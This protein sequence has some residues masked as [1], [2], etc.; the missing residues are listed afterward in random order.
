MEDLI[1]K[2]R[3]KFDLEVNDMADAWK[4]V[5]WLEEKGW[6]VYIIT[7]KDRKQVDAWHPRYGTLFA[8]FGEVPNFGS[9]L[10]GIL[11]V[12]LL[13]KEIEENGFKRTK[14]R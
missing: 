12:A 9:I 5:E 7:A 13:A 10:E 14:A 4:L 6:V 2:V 8:Q 11:T 1:G 3:E